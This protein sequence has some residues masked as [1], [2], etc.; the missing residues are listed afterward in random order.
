MPRPRKRRDRRRTA[1]Q[2]YQQRLQREDPRWERL[3]GRS[4]R[5]PRTLIDA[6]TVANA[7][8]GL[9]TFAAAI[10]TDRPCWAQTLRR[11]AEQIGAGYSEA[12]AIAAMTDEPSASAAFTETSFSGDAAAFSEGVFAEEIIDEPE[13]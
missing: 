2:A 12:A 10:D 5:I 8:V 11:Y 9:L 6:S 4:G 7:K 1:S 13:V 3:T